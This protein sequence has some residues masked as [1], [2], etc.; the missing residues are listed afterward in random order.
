VTQ[1]PPGAV[2]ADWLAGGP[3]AGQPA[4]PGTPAG[5]IDDSGLDARTH[6]LVR[7]AARIASGQCG[8]SCDEQV[9]A[10][11]DYGVTADEIAGVLVALL[12]TLDAV[13]I[14]DAAPGVLGAVARATASSRPEP[15]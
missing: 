10:A 11:L 9:A 4:G 3:A 15:A 13:R 5:N 6:A 8:T 14:R 7:L 2:V 1:R 12:P